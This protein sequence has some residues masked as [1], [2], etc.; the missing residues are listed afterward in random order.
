ML[1]ITTLFQKENTPEALEEVTYP[2][3]GDVS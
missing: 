2:D 3:L 1:N